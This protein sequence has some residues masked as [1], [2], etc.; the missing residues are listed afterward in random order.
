MTM[1]HHSM[2][3]PPVL[4][5][6]LRSR[7][8]VF[9]LLIAIAM[10]TIP[11]VAILLYVVNVDDVV[12]CEGTVVPEHHYLLS[13]AFDARVKQI[14]FLTG[15]K[16]KAGDA[17]VLLDDTEFV[18]GI[19]QTKAEIAVLEAEAKVLKSDLAVQLDMAE[20]QNE[21]SIVEAEMKILNAQVQVKKNELETLKLEPLPENYRHAVP[22]LKAAREAHEQAQANLVQ[23][24]PVLTKREFGTYEKDARLAELDLAIREE[25]ARIVESGLGEQAI[26]KAESEIKV[27]EQQIGEKKVRL[28][29]L[30]KKLLYSRIPEKGE[31]PLPPD[32]TTAKLV[33]KMQ[34]QLHVIERKIEEKKVQV[35]ILNRKIADCRIC[36]VEDG[37]ILEMPC[38]KVMFAERGKPAVEM[39]CRELMVLAEVDSRFIRKINEG[40]E[41]DISSEI[42]NRLQYGKFGG[43][44]EKISDVP[45]ENTSKYPVW[46]RLDTKECDIKIGSKAEVKIIT[47]TSRAL[48]WF[49][50]ITKDDE[51]QLRL[52]ELR[53]K[54]AGRKRGIF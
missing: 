7:I 4:K 33:E 5:T 15:D 38:K 49:M 32:S 51:T 9:T 28:D 53:K 50:N 40:Q 20:I 26:R 29:I 19:E 36:A 42:F 16:V 47:G 11:L 27:I 39:G 21:I 54:E 12:I 22:Q 52:Q 17:I 18:N 35:E 2:T 6:G 8:R 37:T 46:L 34:N 45:L 48:F 3:P 44:V 25:N 23:Y 41:G 30:Q 13:S 31:A 1:L 10:F 14:L 24:K 43:I